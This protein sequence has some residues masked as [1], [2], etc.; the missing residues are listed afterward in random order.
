MTELICN[1]DQGVATV[2]LNRPEAR[3]ALS[4]A[5]RKQLR[6][7]I[8]ELDRDNEVRVIVLTGTDP[9]FCSG[10]DLKEM[11]SDVPLPDVGPFTSPFLTSCTPLIGAVNG[12]AYTGGFE[13]ALACHMLIA[14]ERATFADTHA[15]L[16]LTP[17]WGLTVLLT[18]AI[19]SRRAREL[20][21][22]SQ[23]IDAQTARDWGLVNRVVPHD[24][25]L[26]EADSMARAIAANDVRAVQRLSRL[27]DDQAATRDAAA[28]RLEARAWIGSD[29][30]SHPR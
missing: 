25:L 8:A 1:V 10:V 22:S 18:E 21:L 15:R 4:S 13:L 16:G 3:N 30:S 29:L 17:G 20:S 19:G 6:A 24:R 12:P 14:S 11:Q 26:D 23:P 2:T 27:Y 7:T 9:A 5:L 28:W